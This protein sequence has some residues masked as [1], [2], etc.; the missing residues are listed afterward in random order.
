VLIPRPRGWHLD[1]KHVLID[2][3]PVAGGIF[4]FALY[5]FHNA[6]EAL[7]RGTGPYF[8]L[9]KMESHLEAR[10]WNDIFK[11]SQDELGVPRGSIKA[12]AL[13]RR[14][15]SPRSRWTNSLWELREHSA[16]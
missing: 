3:T 9:P 12:T 6:K 1:E 2:G 14:P 8:Y 11:L 5:F 10:L 16:V 4:D 13:D 15:C 7:A